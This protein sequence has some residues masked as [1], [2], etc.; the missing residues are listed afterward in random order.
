MMIAEK[1]VIYCLQNLIERDPASFTTLYNKNI[2][3]LF[4]LY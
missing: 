3:I 2:L 4:K 1:P